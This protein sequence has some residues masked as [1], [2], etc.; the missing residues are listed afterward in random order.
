[1]LLITA[2]QVQSMQMCTRKTKTLLQYTHSFN[3][4][5]LRNKN[6]RQTICNFMASRTN[7]KY[8]GLG[9]NRRIGNLFDGNCLGDYYHILFE[10][11]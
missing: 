8:K 7:G 3:E 4:L 5:A 1:M 9:G 11:K 2:G 10:H 6:Y